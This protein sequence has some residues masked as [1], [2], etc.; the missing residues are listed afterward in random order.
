MTRAA[1]SDQAAAGQKHGQQSRESQDGASSADSGKEAKKDVKTDKTDKTGQTDKTDQ[2][3]QT[4]QTVKTEQTDQTADAGKAVADAKIAQPTEDKDATPM[5]D[6]KPADA[7]SSPM[8][9]P[10]RR[11]IPCRRSRLPW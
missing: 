1:R 4:D 9:P 10:R 2:T 7:S 8:P 3:D 11:P 6:G 5:N